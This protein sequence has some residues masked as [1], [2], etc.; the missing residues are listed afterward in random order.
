MNSNSLTVK[1]ALL[2]AAGNV[3]RDSPAAKSEEKRMFS[4]AMYI[5]SSEECV[6]KELFRCILIG[7]VSLFCF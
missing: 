4:Q 3:S 7:V 2:F 6:V 1:C 5:E